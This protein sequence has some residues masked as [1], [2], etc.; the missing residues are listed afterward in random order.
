[1]NVF[2]KLLPVWFLVFYYV[3][4]FKSIEF[5]HTGGD[6]SDILFLR[7]FS[8]GLLILLTNKFFYLLDSS[9]V[10]NIFDSKTVNIKNLSQ[11]D[12]NIIG[13]YGV[14]LCSN[15]ISNGEVSLKFGFRPS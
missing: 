5:K 13:S 3:C 9:N 12:V 11:A 1:M 4:A 14:L 7:K 2:N 8:D 10:D 15:Q 6:G